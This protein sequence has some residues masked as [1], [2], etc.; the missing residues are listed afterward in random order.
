MNQKSIKQT[1]IT[2]TNNIDC[3][4]ND[5]ATLVTTSNIFQEDPT[6]D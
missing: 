4:M 3:Q 6:K 1:K 5:D 2:P